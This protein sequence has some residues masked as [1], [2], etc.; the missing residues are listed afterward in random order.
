MGA[1]RSVLT[2]SETPSYDPEEVP[3]VALHTHTC[4]ACGSRFEAVRSDAEMCSNRCRLR[5]HRERERARREH[6]AAEVERAS[7]LL[8][9]LR[10]AS[11]LPPGD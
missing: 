3:A 11:A 10:A 2:R 4:A 7:L 9:S 5:R 1:L 6:T 8:A